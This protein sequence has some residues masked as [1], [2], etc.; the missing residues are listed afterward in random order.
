M[1]ILNVLIADSQ[2]VNGN[3]ATQSHSRHVQSNPNAAYSK[4]VDDSL[5][6]TFIPEVSQM[7]S[8]AHMYFI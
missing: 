3:C 8:S 4:T 2:L 1:Y 5:S 6:S 7:N